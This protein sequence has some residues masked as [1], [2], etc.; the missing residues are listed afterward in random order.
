MFFPPSV[1]S[2]SIWILFC[3]HDRG[4]TFSYLYGEPIILISFIEEPL[5]CDVNLY[6]RLSTYICMNQFLGYFV[7]LI[8]L[9]PLLF[10]LAHYTFY[11][12]ILQYCTLYTTSAFVLIS[13]QVSSIVLKN[14]LRCLYRFIFPCDFQNLVIKF[15]ELHCCHTNF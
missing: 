11:I 15:P 6:H 5:I 1:Y 12:N 9:S 8:S 4:Y 14:Y 7:S 3:V 2:Y 10:T 13:D